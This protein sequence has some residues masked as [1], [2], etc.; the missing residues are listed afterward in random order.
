MNTPLSTE[1][2]PTDT[3]LARWVACLDA[4]PLRRVR[5]AVRMASAAR[6]EE[7]VGCVVRGLLGARHR[8]LRCVTRV[9]RCDGCPV[10]AHCDYARLFGA[11]DARPP[12]PEGEARAF[13]WQGVPMGRGLA[14]GQSFEAILTFVPSALPRWPH[15]VSAA[16]DALEMLGPDQAPLNEVRVIEEGAVETA[17]PEGARAWRVST[18]SPVGLRG[19]RSRGAA[20]CPSA[21]W[22]EPLASEGLQRISQLVATFVGERTPRVS[23]PDL[24][25]VERLEGEMRPWAESRF[26]HRQGKRVPMAGIEGSVV[27]RG[28]GVDALVPLLRALEVTGVGKNTAMGMGALRVEPVG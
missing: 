16:L 25:G 27:L 15:L 10:A 9:D 6:F 14:A 1:P 5:Y 20:R 3:S 26:T 12:T 2:A 4:L 13:W 7:P 28:A 11:P 8:G 18:R 24:I 19:D 17:G 22:L 21:D 23:L